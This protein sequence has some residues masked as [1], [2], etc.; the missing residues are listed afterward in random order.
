MKLHIKIIA[1]CL[2]SFVLTGCNLLSD[3]LA[4][5]LIM[6]I[7]D[8]GVYMSSGVGATGSKPEQF[9][10]YELLLER[11]GQSDWEHLLKHESPVVRAYAS[12]ALL[13][14]Y[15]ENINV[16]EFT[17]AMLKD[18][19]W[20]S[21]FI[22]CFPGAKR[23]GGLVVDF[24]Q[25]FL[26]ADEYESILSIAIKERLDFFFV[27]MHLW[28]GVLIPELYDDIKL[29]AGLGSR[30]AL[31][32]LGRYGKIEDKEFILELKKESAD[33]YDD[34]LSMFEYK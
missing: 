17:K 11:F 2:I 32:A 7:A 31:Y 13:G 5:P 24:A 19:E 8:E 33:D 16:Y 4:D 34:V 10:R 25:P 18:Y 21:T 27:D 20:V 22:G 14:K 29:W 30:P 23:V 28:Q 9:K 1:T 15:G 12:S 26:S 6:E 3:P